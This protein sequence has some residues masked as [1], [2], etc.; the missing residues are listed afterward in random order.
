[1]LDE[2]SIVEQARRGDERAWRELYER[3]VEL[4]FGLAYRIVNDRDVALDVVQETYLKASGAIARFRGDSSVRSWLASIALNEARSWVRKRGRERQVALD[5]IQEPEARERGAD[6]VVADADLAGRA[7]EFIATLPDQQRDA[8][9][10]RTTE[11]L[12]YREI[13]EV[14]G[15][16]EGSVRVSYHLGLAK[17]RAHM[18]RYTRPESVG[19]D[20]VVESERTI[21]GT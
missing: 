2:R 3:N 17:L 1:M 8:V 4:V 5:A 7:L 20:G 9:L 11:G 14:V 19:G 21:D 16:S 13:A 18:D 6:D 10:L 15:S 12:S